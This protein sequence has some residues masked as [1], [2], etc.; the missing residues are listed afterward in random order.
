MQELAPESPGLVIVHDQD[1]HDELAGYA[2]CVKFSVDFA[3]IHDSRVAKRSPC[4]RER[5]SA[6]GVVDYLDS[7]ECWDIVGAT[8]AVDGQSEYEGVIRVAATQ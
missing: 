3:A 8:V 1:V 7:A 5:L 4:Y 6:H 2:E